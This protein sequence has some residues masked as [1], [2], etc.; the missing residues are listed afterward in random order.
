MNPY[1]RQIR[2]QT[3]VHKA[4]KC[5]QD[6]NFNLDPAWTQNSVQEFLDLEN[7]AKKMFSPPVEMR[8][9]SKIQSNKST[10]HNQKSKDPQSSKFL[11]GSPQGHSKHMSESIKTAKTT[12]PQP[13]YKS[14]A[15][16]FSEHNKEKAK[17]AEDF[18]YSTSKKRHGYNK[19]LNIDIKTVFGKPIDMKYGH[20]TTNKSNANTTTA[21][22]LNGPPKMP[23]V[24]NRHV[25][26]LSMTRNAS[27]LSVGPVK[28]DMNAG[29]SQ[30]GGSDY[31]LGI[32]R[33][34]KNLSMA[35]AI[36]DGKPESIFGNRGIFNT[37]GGNNGKTLR[38]VSRSKDN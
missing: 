30:D 14:S 23:I 33:K 4:G 26:E 7:Q 16:I 10:Y 35:E 18:L 29:N 24:K 5:S 36:V 2:P 9:Y 19:K 25:S 31:N 12:K 38:E 6:I 17:Q 37:T 20:T 32:R 8:T 11:K 1:S 27:D 13:T 21:N 3:A 28:A 22:S 15:T 34:C